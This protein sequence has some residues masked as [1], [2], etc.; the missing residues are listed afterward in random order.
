MRFRMNSLILFGILL[1]FLGWLLS[2]TLGSIHIPVETIIDAFIR[3]DSENSLHLLV[4]QMRLPRAIGGAFIGSALA[5]AGALMQGMTRNPLADT[6]L[7]GISAGA[8]FT[9][10]IMMAYFSNTP[11]VIT[12]LMAFIGSGVSAFIIFYLSRLAGQTRVTQMV[13]AGACL[14]GLLS[15]LS[16]AVA[17]GNEMTLN[18]AYWTMG[19][20]GGMNISKLQ[21]A[22]PIITIAIGI[23]IYI[24]P[25]LSLISMGDEIATGLG[26]NIEA[27]KWI[28]MLLV[29]I[30]SGTSVALSGMIAFVGLIV[31][32]ICRTLVGPDYR[33]ILPCS[34]IWGGV[35]LVY[36]DVLSRVWIAPSEIPIGAV[37]ALIGAPMFLYIASRQ[38]GG[39]KT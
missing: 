21:L 13:L 34:A 11:Y 22:I 26:V 32:H 4:I 19:S 14:S 27:V 3:Y 39:A 1:L 33:Y 35:L 30:L 12:M 23:A 24:A 5:V 2:V 17:I 7:L 10:A 29:I 9:I 16:Q 15:S 25:K 37:V 6:G 18:L 8:T 20:L 31:P 38:K 36:S 28:I